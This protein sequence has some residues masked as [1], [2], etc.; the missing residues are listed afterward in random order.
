MSERVL[1]FKGQV[2]VVTGAASGLG[3]ETA[4]C[5]IEQG[6]DVILNYR[7]GLGDLELLVERAHA[8][9]QRA[10]LVQANVADDVDCARI[11]R[12]TAEWGRVDMLVNNAGV[13]KHVPHDNLA[14]LNATDFEQIFAV[15]LVGPYQLTRALEP[16]IAMAHMLAQSPR[17]VVMVSSVAGVLANGSSIAYS[18]SK[19]ALNNMTMALAR[20]LAPAARVNAI[21]PGYIDTPWFAKGTDEERATAVRQ[22]AAQ[23]TPLKLAAQPEEIARSIVSLSS[24]DFMH[25]TGT[26][27][28]VDDG[29]SLLGAI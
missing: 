18:A 22:G 29:L 19:A 20:V 23:I 27:V 6:A 3:Y 25:M 26:T 7:S 28:L 11:A 21:C 13:S 5:F 16:M 8:Y 24:D 10:M 1:R 12:C 15:N 14:N 9:G 17:S 2:A 4:A